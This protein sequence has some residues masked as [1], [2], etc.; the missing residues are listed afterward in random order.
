MQRMYLHFWG[1]K[2][3]WTSQAHALL[4][5]AMS[6]AALVGM[7]HIMITL[8]I[9]KN[10]KFYTF[11]TDVLYIFNRCPIPAYFSV[12]KYSTFFPTLVNGSVWIPRFFQTLF[13]K[14]TSA[15]LKDSCYGLSVS[16]K[17]SCV[18]NLIP[19]AIALGGNK[20][21]LSH[22]PVLGIPKCDPSLIS[23]L[24]DNWD[25]WQYFIIA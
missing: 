11:S 6:Q 8:W 15:V 1:S 13:S 3:R 23:T 18:R 12:I 24:A 21:Y 25:W 10:S 20:R 5:F 2:N 4:C 17:S 16:L 14:R 9:G 7:I 22:I 19:N